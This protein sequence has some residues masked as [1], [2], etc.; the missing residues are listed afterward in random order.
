VVEMITKERLETC[1]KASFP[2]GS[3]NNQERAKL[4]GKII[5]Y[6]AFND[7]QYLFQWVPDNIGNSFNY[8]IKEINLL[9]AALSSIE[10]VEE[11]IAGNIV[12]YFVT[13]D[14]FLKNVNCMVD[15]IL[16]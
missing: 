6:V 11:C 10:P 7:P 8:L 3:Q 14:H 15:I 1:A 5:L 4:E 9:S 2:L 12:R 13:N 16:L